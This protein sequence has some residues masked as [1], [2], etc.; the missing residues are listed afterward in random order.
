VDCKVYFDRVKNQPCV[1]WMCHNM[2][3]GLRSKSPSRPSDHGPSRDGYRAIFS[4]GG[5]GRWKVADESPAVLFEQALDPC[6]VK[7]FLSPPSR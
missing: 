3:Y 1:G 5:P 6:G 2:S 7:P 4:T